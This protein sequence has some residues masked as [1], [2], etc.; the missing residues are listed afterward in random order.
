MT[1]PAAALLANQELL[2]AV[3]CIGTY[4]EFHSIRN[5]L[6]AYLSAPLPEEVAKLCA[7]LRQ[8]TGHYGTTS[9]DGGD[10]YDELRLEAAD[11]LERLTLA[12]KK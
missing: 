8:P 1:A 4:K 10:S 3:R 6:A 5:S 12:E 9:E 11:M 2:E 7:K